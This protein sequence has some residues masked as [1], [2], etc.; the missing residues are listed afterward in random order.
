MATC[1]QG[2]CFDYHILVTQVC[3]E[4]HVIHFIALKCCRSTVVCVL[5]NTSISYWQWYKKNI[6]I[7]PKKP[8]QSSAT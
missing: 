8:Y 1:E 6:S 4:F 7:G 2:H 3:A 5:Q